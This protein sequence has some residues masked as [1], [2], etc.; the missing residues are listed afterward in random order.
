MLLI[1]S[2]NL[3]AQD[4][5][6]C[7]KTK[8]NIM[9][10]FPPEFYEYV[11]DF[12]V[13][14]AFAVLEV[15]D[16]SENEFKKLKTLFN[17]QM[18]RD[19]FPDVVFFIMSYAEQSKNEGLLYTQRIKDVDESNK[20]LW[21]LSEAYDLAVANLT[22][23]QDE[24]GYLRTEVE[25]GLPL[26]TMDCSEFVSRYL[27]NIGV[28]TNT[29]YL[30]TDIMT[31]TPLDDAKLKAMEIKKD[32]NEYWVN[33]KI[34]ADIN[35]NRKK[36]HREFHEKMQFIKGSDMH[37]PDFDD[38]KSGDIFV[39]RN[40]NSGHTGIVL[41]YEKS[42]D[43]V[44]V[45]EAIGSSREESLNK[46]SRQDITRISQYQ[47]NGNALGSHPGSFSYFRPKKIN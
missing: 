21:G 19:R 40:K 3:M 35:E 15:T 44:Y 28:F 4:C 33:S 37:S 25:H 8:E 32:T 20:L 7:E 23:H 5:E 12:N 6:P 38:V 31:K 27:K 24:G 22:Y 39:W 26:L 36:S 10:S 1:L 47:K 17:A 45:M 9:A 34:I 46:N 11:R 14:G 16:I 42:S 13:N 30:T 18:L 43:I 2:C 29:P 41:H